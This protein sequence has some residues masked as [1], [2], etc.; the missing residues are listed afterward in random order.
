MAPSPYATKVSFNP[1]SRR[2]SVLQVIPSLSP[3]Y[4]GP[5][6][7]MGVIERA[8][9]AAGV[10]VETATADDDGLG[11]APRPAGGWDNGI[12]RHTFTRTTRAY[13]FAATFPAWLKQHVR[14]Y[15]VV[16]VHGAFS[17]LPMSAAHVARA[18]GVPF[19]FS[20]HGM[21]LDYGLSR[22]RL[23]KALSLPVFE[24]PALKGAAAVH[25]TAAAERDEIA[26]RF[27]KDLRFALI[28]L[29]VEPGPSGEAARFIARFPELAAP[30]PR[31]LFL[32]RIEPKKNLE[33][34]IDAMP[35]LGDLPSGPARLVVC[36]T[37]D[38]AY[39]TG[40]RQRAAA[41]GVGA[42]ITWSGFVA[43]EA[44]GDAL[45][46][47]DL[48]VLPSFSENFGVAPVE[49]MLAGVP[50]VLGEGVAIAEEVAAAGAGRAIQ[51]TADAVASAIRDMLGDDGGERRRNAARELAYK[52]YAPDVMARELVALYQRILS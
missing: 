8:L 10:R 21:L 39:V 51:P 47:A 35:E 3:L 19:V 31:L 25:V 50:C 22:S 7:A 36:G 41:L 33:A 34:L 11:R 46:W 13:T 30:G 9:L 16:H 12:F 45:A 2:L 4:G 24:R 6:A 42:R 1:P 44:K 23:K 40:L 49:A 14:D 5:S 28:P 26:R 17:H 29:G 48:F 52:R 43:G 20:P 18:Q 15:D 38:D 32:S 37:G 27:G